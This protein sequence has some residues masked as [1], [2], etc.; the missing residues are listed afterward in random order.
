MHKF[1][2]QWKLHSHSYSWTEY[3]AGAVWMTLHKPKYAKTSS[4]K[5]SFKIA[6]SEHILLYFKNSNSFFLCTHDN[7]RYTCCGS[8]HPVMVSFHFRQV[9]T[10]HTNYTLT[11]IVGLN[12]KRAL[13]E[14]R[15]TNQNMLKQVVPKKNISVTF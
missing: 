6:V 11:V 13:F 15:F 9:N 10:L 14:W 8:S 7:V 2:K 4:P 3:K 12:I 5:D 1:E